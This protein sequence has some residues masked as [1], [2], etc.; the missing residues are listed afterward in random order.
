MRKATVDEKLTKR[1]RAAALQ[2][3]DAVRPGSSDGVNRIASEE[4]YPVPGEDEL[5]GRRSSLW[6]AA[7]G[8][9]FFMEAN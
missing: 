9:R 1:R 7:A 8:R 2:R 4:S 6:S 5:R 3:V